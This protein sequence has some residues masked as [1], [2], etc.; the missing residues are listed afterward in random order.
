MVSVLSRVK[1]SLAQL[2]RLV[3]FC[4]DRADYVVIKNLYWGDD[5]KFTRYNSS[6]IRQTIAKFGGTEL[7]LPELFDDIFD[8][9]DAND[10]TFREALEHEAFTLSNQ[11]RVYGWITACEKEFD[12]AAGPLGLE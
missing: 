10:L 2:K 7:L 5:N 9:I 3:D 8:L 4:G 12:Q 1:E 6:E 11:S